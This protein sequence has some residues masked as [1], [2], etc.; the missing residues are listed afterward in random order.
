MNGLMH[1]AFWKSHDA[2]PGDVKLLQVD[3]LTDSFGE[4]GFKISIFG[5]EIEDQPGGLNVMVCCMK[6]AGRAS[7]L[8]QYAMLSSFRLV[9]LPNPSEWQSEF[10]CLDM[11][12]RMY[13]NLFSWGWGFVWYLPEESADFRIS[14]GWAPSGW[15][16][17]R[18][19]RRA[20]SGFLILNV[21]FV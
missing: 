17:C 6:P 19:L 8:S 14:R 4:W 13:W 20:E 11:R 10:P 12:L 2:G 21:N 1:D 15:L 16:A 3:Q 7:T 5:H 18:T 9:N